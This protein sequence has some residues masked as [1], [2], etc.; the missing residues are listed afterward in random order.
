MAATTFFGKRGRSDHYRPCESESVKTK[1]DMENVYEKTLQ[2]L[3]QGSRQASDSSSSSM[4]QCFV[5]ARARVSIS[6]NFCNHGMCEMC[7]RQCQECQGIFCSV[8]SIQDYEERE[9]RTFCLE[10]HQDEVATR[11]QSTMMDSPLTSPTSTMH[12]GFSVATHKILV[13]P[14]GTFTRVGITAHAHDSSV[15][16]P[17]S[18]GSSWS[19]ASSAASSFSAASPFHSPFTAPSSSTASAISASP[20]ASSGAAAS[21]SRCSLF[22]GSACSSSGRVGED[23]PSSNPFGSS[24]SGFSFASPSSSSSSS[25]AASP[26]AVPCGLSSSPTA[27]FGGGSYDGGNS[28]ASPFTYV[29]DS[30]DEPMDFGGL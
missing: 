12:Q 21:A 3:L 30:T 22:G 20:F 16:T 7:A 2:M 26:L 15:T 18:A 28:H 27:L 8:C 10:C 17:T 5:C 23:T 25:C 19:N 1:Y 9:D 11:K 29:D 14:D 24:A 6:C 4:D 13:S